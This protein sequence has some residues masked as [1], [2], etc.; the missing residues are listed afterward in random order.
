MKTT[1]ERTRRKALGVGIPVAVM[2]AGLGLY[3]AYWYDLRDRL[4]RHCGC[5]GRAD[6]TMTPQFFLVVGVLMLLGLGTCVAI[7][8]IRRGIRPTVATGAS[9]VGL[10]VGALAAG[11]LATT[12]I[13]EIGISLWQNATLSSLGKSLWMGGSAIIGSAAAWIASSLPSGSDPGTS[14]ASPAMDLASGERAL[15]TATLSAKWPLMLGL[16][17]L[18]PALGLIWIGVRPIGMVLLVLAISITTFSRI[19]V[20]ANQSGLQV[21]YGFLGW[22]RTSV[23]LDRIATAQAIDV[24]PSEWGGWGYRGNLTLMKRAAVVLRGGPGIRLDLHDGKVFV[25]TIDDPDI[26]AQLLNAEASRL[27]PSTA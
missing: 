6:A 17:T 25:V 1:I 19:R 20:T 22:P 11:I 2:G 14:T 13:A 12:A 24:D 8:V 18:L 5:Y 4:A 26:P 9:S 7:A 10:F 3:L 27:E 15:W 16:V 23:P 21:R